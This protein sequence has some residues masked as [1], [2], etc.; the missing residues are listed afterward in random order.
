MPAITAGI[1][2]SI[3]LRSS[4][5]NVYSTFQASNIYLFGQL[6]RPYIYIYF[7]DW[8]QRCESP[9]P[10]VRGFIEQP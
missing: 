6:F 5:L 2:T 10:T 9:F 7:V 8:P 3:I 1:D 4:T